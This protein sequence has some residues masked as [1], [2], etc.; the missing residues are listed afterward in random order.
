V[1]VTVPAPQSEH[2]LL[3]RAR[4]LA[5]RTLGQLAAR[6]DMSVPRD[7]VHGKGFAGTLLERCL[8]ATAG[9][10]ALPDFEAIGVELKT[11]PV[12]GRGHP[13]ESTFVCTIPLIDVASVEW[14]QS[15]VRHK[16]ARV[17][18]FPILSERSIPLA[19]RTVGTSLLW[20]PSVEQEADLRWDW[21]ELAGLIALGHAEDVTGHLGRYLQVRHKARNSHARR[22]GFVADG[23]PAPVLPRGFYLRTQFTARL[24][25]EL[26]PP[27][28]P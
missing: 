13:L 28:T 10:R 20:S 3:E 5:G 25:T 18:W 11:L 14:E 1:A 23:V 16:L 6:F 7:T 22:L 15:R 8:G 12:D 17:L 21:E 4:D 19:D 26:L 27:T 2:E 9:S 24:L